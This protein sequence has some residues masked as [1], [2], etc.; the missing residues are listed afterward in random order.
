MMDRKCSCNRLVSTSHVE[1]TQVVKRGNVERTPRM[2]QRRIGLLKNCMDPGNLPLA[3]GK[4][5]GRAYELPM[6]P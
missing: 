3:D 6:E 5:F 2:I 1:R 4:V